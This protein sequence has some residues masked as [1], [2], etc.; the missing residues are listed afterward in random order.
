MSTVDSKTCPHGNVSQL[1]SRDDLGEGWVEP[2]AEEC[3]LCEGKA[4]DIPFKP[5]P[6]QRAPGASS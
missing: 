1:R 6:P 5:G 3:R 4:A 2:F